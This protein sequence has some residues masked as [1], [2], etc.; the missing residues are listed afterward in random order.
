LTT[1]ADGDHDWKEVGTVAGGVVD[2]RPT[3][4]VGVDGSA[5]SR[6][7]L[8]YALDD[9]VRR[10]ARVRV[11]SVV[12]EPEYWAVAYG[13]SAPAP[14]GEMTAGLEKA[15]RQTVDDVRAEQLGRA[16]VPVEVLALVG[17]PATVLVE[18]AR[19]ADL[20]VLGHR[21]VGGIASSVL[22]SVGLQCVL[23]APGAVTIVRADQRVEREP[24]EPRP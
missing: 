9:A 13:M 3:I 10:G 12:V 6:A 1:V 15:A 2:E 14:L 7:A 18:Q 11:V 21:G 5:G 16:D 19:D 4:V 8:R 23:H 17:P 22:G 20:L 24:A